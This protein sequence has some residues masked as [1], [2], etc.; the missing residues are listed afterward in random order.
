[1]VPLIVQSCKRSDASL[2][3][4]VKELRSDA[5]LRS[6]DDSPFAEGTFNFVDT[7]MLGID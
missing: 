1:M 2:V 6:E 7:A 4:G 5:S 3:L